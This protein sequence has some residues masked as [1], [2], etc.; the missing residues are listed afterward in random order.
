MALINLNDPELRS[1][2]LVLRYVGAFGLVVALALW[3]KLSPQDAVAILV[4]S[5]WPWSHML[6][7]LGIVEP[8]PPCP[9]GTSP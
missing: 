4:G 2:L 8:A 6:E 7:G 5:V 1:Y 3:G 9:P